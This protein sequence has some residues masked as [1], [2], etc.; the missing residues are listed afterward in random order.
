V[1]FANRGGLARRGGARRRLGRGLVV[2]ISA[3]AIRSSVAQDDV[4]RH[5]EQERAH[6]RGIAHPRAMLHAL[7]ERALCEIVGRMR[8]PSPNEAVDRGQV[9]V[10]ERL[11]GIRVAVAPALDEL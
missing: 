2:S 10:E 4:P 1:F 6:A 8:R 3:P 7:E 9:A 5:A 11:A